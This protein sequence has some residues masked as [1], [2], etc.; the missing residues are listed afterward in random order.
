MPHLSDVF[1]CCIFDRFLWYYIFMTTKDKVLEELQSRPG[2]YVSGSQIAS[3]LNISRNA[4]WKAIERL[5]ADGYQIEAI[6]HKG[7]KLIALSDK[8]VPSIISRYLRTLGVD[9][10]HIA[11]IYFYGELASTNR[12]AKEHIADGAPH[13]TSVIARVL[14]EDK[15]ANPDNPKIYEDN[16][17]MSIILRSQSASIDTAQTV[18]M[19]VVSVYNAIKE[20][21][22]KICNIR[23]ADDLYMGK[24]KICDIYTEGAGVLKGGVLKVISNILG[25]RVFLSSIPLNRSLLAANIL[26]NLIYDEPDVNT[27]NSLYESYCKNKE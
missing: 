22:G 14:N 13:G 3:H 4:I 27:I 19:C 20:M 2:E 18:R 7:Y 5:R 25:I 6:T 23:N 11:P 15:T 26:K 9:K 10:S 24:H 12:K 8:L 17:N 1:F 21:T 16:L